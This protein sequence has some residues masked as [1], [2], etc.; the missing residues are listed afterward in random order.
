MN[1]SIIAVE[2][3]GSREK[4]KMSYGAHL[5]IQSWLD[6]TRYPRRRRNLRVWYLRYSPFAGLIAS[7]GIE[8]PVYHCHIV[9]LPP[10]DVTWHKR[11]ISCFDMFC[12][13]MGLKDPK[14][15]LRRWA[16]YCIYRYFQVHKGRRLDTLLPLK[17]CLFGEIFVF[18]FQS[19]R[20]A[21]DCQCSGHGKSICI[22]GL[23]IDQQRNR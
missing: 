14:G 20:S 13:P 5:V 19:L 1:C 2:A 8:R 15:N 23:S 10:S 16:H 18:S 4:P 6:Y 3:K 22:E 9:S 7:R 11:S 12:K 17:S 21:G